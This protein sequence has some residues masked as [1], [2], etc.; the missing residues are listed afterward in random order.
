MRSP[1]YGIVARRVL[2]ARRLPIVLSYALSLLT[3]IGMLVFW[4]VYVLRS[5]QRVAELAGRL[6]I[7][8][9]NV[10]WAVL[11]VGCL[12]F[13]ML[14]VMMHVTTAQILSTESHSKDNQNQPKGVDIA[15]FHQ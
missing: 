2:R 13:F 10:Q 12:A 7:R 4:V 11:L 6:G 14:M 15:F 3:T 5:S 8:G 9:D 1:R